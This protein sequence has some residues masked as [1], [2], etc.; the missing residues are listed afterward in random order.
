[1]SGDVPNKS[2]YLRAKTRHRVILTM[3]IVACA[4][5]GLVSLGVDQYGLTLSDIFRIIGDRMEYGV[6]S[7][8][9]YRVYIEDY[10][11][12]NS[13][14]PRMV[15]V[16]T[17]GAI[18]AVGGVVM[19][20]TI[21][22][23]LADPYTTGISSGALLG[24]SLFLILDVALIPLSGDVGLAVNAFVFSLIPCSI[25]IGFSMFRKTTPAL[26][27]LIGIATS[28]LFSA[29]IAVINYTAAPDDLS[30]VYEWGIGTMAT[31]GSTAVPFLIV[32]MMGIIIVMMLFARRINVVSVDD[33]FARSLG[34]DATRI[35]IVC[36][37]MVSLFTSIAV[38]FVGTI[39]FI[40]LVVPHF[41]RMFVGSDNRKLIPM[42]AVMGALILML[43][44]CLARSLIT[45]GLPVG[46]ITSIIGGPVL[47]FLLIR[48]NKSAW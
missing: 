14:I 31:M 36:L 35:R 5:I 2:D 33:N 9:D 29:V 7:Q 20:S 34:V 4:V 32:S 48:M 26:I 19:Q 17:V 18:L 15:G 28:L 24:V 39:G 27:V 11:V 30:K 12:F 44:D 16:I 45:G 40:G 46:L 41:A 8:D 1:M 38:S 3:G 10:L 47:L 25:I 43:A 13:F 37:V 42:S 23:P 22:N 21:R 6:P